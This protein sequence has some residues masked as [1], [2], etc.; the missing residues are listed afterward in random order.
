V[1]TP[2]AIKLNICST[3]LRMWGPCSNKFGRRLSYN[4][5]FFY[6]P[7]FSKLFG[8]TVMQKKTYLRASKKTT[9]D[10]VGPINL[11]KICLAQKVWR[12]LHLS[13]LDISVTF[14][15]TRSIL[16][17]SQ[18]PCIVLLVL[19]GH[20]WIVNTY[21]TKMATTINKQKILKR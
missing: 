8:H 21:S 15:S 18:N 6:I 2:G 1:T 5:F 13:A 7:L 9:F 14:C 12:L 20:L 19:P 16:H 4:P 3:R 11:Q 17:Y 10:N